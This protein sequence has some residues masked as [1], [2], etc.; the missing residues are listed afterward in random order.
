MAENGTKFVHAPRLVCVELNPG[1]GRGEN[2]GDEEKWRIV[3]YKK[4]LKC[5]IIEFQKNA[6]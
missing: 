5:L 4:D 6:N 3:I 1:P 2:L